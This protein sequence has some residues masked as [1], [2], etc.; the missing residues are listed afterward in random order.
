MSAEMFLKLTIIFFMSLFVTA[1]AMSAF[2]MMNSY[3]DKV[4]LIHESIGIIFLIVL[5]IH[6]YLRKDKLKK[7]ILDFFSETILHKE[8]SSCDNGKLLK[9]LK[10]RALNEICEIF[11]IDFEDTLSMLRKKQIIVKERDQKLEEIALLN[12]HDSLKILGMILEQHIR[13]QKNA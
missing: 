10:S 5:P 1:I 11:N 4:A 9:T 2:M 6:I 3:D 12:S 7:M 8:M 13:G